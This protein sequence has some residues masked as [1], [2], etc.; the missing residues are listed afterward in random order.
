VHDPAARLQVA[1]ETLVQPSVARAQEDE[2]GGVPPPQEGLAKDLPEEHGRR[3]LRRLVEDGGGQGIP[4]EPP[5][6]RA[7]PRAGEP[8]G[9]REATGN[10]ARPCREAE[11]HH[12]EARAPGQ[13]QGQEAGQKVPGCGQIRAVQRGPPPIVAIVDAQALL[14]EEEVRGPRPA[15]QVQGRL[16]T[17]DHQV[18]AVV[19]VFTGDGVRE[20]GGAAAEDAPPLEERDL[21]PALLEG[22]GGGESREAAP[23]DDD[24]H[25]RV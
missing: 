20:R 23:D 25:R 3:A 21:V 22:D 10:P 2:P 12:V 4:D 8:L 18:R 24:P 1:R 17:R 16:V 11:A 14:H 15:Q 5:R 6:L 19:H 9:Q 7:L 13:A